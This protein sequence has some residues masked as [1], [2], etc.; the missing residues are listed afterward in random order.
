[1]YSDLHSRKDDELEERDKKTFARVVLLASIAVAVL[2]SI[3]L[4]VLWL[5][6]H[7]LRG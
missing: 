7:F 5:A 1:M 2:F 3:G 6:P 4:L